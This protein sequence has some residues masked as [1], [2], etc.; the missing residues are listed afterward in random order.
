MEK[1]ARASE[2]ARN[3]ERAR[4]AG[5]EKTRLHARI[6][7]IQALEPQ[8]R[9]AGEEKTRLHARIQALEQQL[10][11]ASHAGQNERVD[12]SGGQPS[13]PKQEDLSI[14]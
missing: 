14:V 11:E 12:G 8:L 9:E 6:L 5:E 13:E 10:R 4:E 7:E 1:A 2:S 3:D